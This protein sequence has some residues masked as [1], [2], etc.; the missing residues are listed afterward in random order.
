MEAQQ[1]VICALIRPHGG[2]M[3]EPRF[4]ALLPISPKSPG[5]KASSTGAGHP[6]PEHSQ[7]LVSKDRGALV[8]ATMAKG[9]RD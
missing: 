6:A 9:Q 7:G 1:R 2:S 8:S 5:T 3:P 4:S